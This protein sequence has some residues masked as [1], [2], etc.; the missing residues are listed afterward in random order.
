MPHSLAAR[1]HDFAALPVRPGALRRGL[2]AGSAW[3]IIMGAILTA[4]AAWE[5][6][7]LCLTD[8]ALSTA[9]AIGAGLCTIGPLAAF[10]ARTA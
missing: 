2:I 6:G 10:G 9:L 8:A 1:L 3:G 4:L 7:G 5:C